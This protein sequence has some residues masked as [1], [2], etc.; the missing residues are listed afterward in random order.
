MITNNTYGI[1]GYKAPKWGVDSWLNS[2]IKG[3][4]P[5]LA[6]YEGKVLYLYFFQS[7]CPGCHSHGFPTLNSLKERYA[8]HPNVA[9][10]AIQTVF[11][12]FATNTFDAAK[13]TA[14]KHQLDIPVGHD[15]N[16][17]EHFSSVMGNY[18]SGGTPWTVLI[19]KNGYVRFNDF[20]ATPDQMH[21]MIETL[22]NES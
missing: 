9:F 4:G 15:A 13:A 18:R 17:E 22:L 1:A 2:P 14:K 5:T 19:D 7:W 3:Q 12:G 21:N 10:V 6:D 8:D 20:R 16:L 11:E